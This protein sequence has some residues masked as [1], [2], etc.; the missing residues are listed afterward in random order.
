M[1]SAWSYHTKRSQIVPQLPTAQPDTH[2][3]WEWERELSRPRPELSATQKTQPLPP[4]QYPGTESLGSSGS[5][6]DWRKTPA[7]GSWAAKST[8]LD[9]LQSKQTHSGLVTRGTKPTASAP[10]SLE[11]H[12][13]P[14]GPLLSGRRVSSRPHSHHWTALSSW[15]RTAPHCPGE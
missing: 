6:T 14:C 1:L 10:A 8:G 11:M 7:T 4:G 9:T 2:H 12:P 5:S 3:T 13:G 15:I